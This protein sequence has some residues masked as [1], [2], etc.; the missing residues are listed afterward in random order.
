[1]QILEEH[2]DEPEI[3]ALDVGAMNTGLMNETRVIE[4]T[5]VRHYKMTLQNGTSAYTHHTSMLTHITH[6]CA[7]TSTETQRMAQQCNDQ[8]DRRRRPFVSHRLIQSPLLRSLRK[9][10]EE[11]ERK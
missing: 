6:A 1:M 9:E 4:L 5:E 3:V 10:K 7:C 11:K 8:T 2:V